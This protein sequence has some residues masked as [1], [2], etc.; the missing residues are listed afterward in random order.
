MMD[1]KCIDNNFKINSYLQFTDKNTK[2]QY[3]E[4]GEYD[5]AHFITLVHLS[6]WLLLSKLPT[7]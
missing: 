7:V 6:T 4:M 3:K 5:F 2:N 1:P